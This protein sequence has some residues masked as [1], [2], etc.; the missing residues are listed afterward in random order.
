MKNFE[1]TGII[2]AYQTEIKN[3]LELVNLME[4]SVQP[5]QSQYLESKNKL[6]EE[7]YKQVE[8]WNAVV[9]RD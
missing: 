1:D 3:A 8:Y 2:D 4:T 6:L 9:T 7:K 5:Q